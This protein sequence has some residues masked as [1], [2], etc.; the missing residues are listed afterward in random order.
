MYVVLGAVLCEFY[1]C[2]L[3]TA[4]A[5]VVNMRYGLVMCITVCCG[6]HYMQCASSRRVR[7]GRDTSGAPWGRAW[8]DR[9]VS[10]LGE[11][12]AGLGVIL[13]VRGASSGL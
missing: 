8:P 13:P 5:C 9:R 10:G 3:T 12:L 4:R 2:T 7:R 11:V 1:P 6:L